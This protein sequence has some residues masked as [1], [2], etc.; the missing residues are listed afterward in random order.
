MP[1]H[2]KDPENLSWPTTDED[3]EAVTL[4]VTETIMSHLL[5]TVIVHVYNVINHVSIKTNDDKRR[6]TAFASVRTACDLLY[7]EVYFNG[8]NAFIVA[9]SGAPQNAHLPGVQLTKEA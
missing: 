4:K 3:K 5:E 8:Y 1:K 2:V 7:Y 9:Q 6:W